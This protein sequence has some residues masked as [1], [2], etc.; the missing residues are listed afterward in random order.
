MFFI[1]ICLPPTYS[2]SV[3]LCLLYFPCLSPTLFPASFPHFPLPL[4]YAFPFL[5][6]ML[7]L[8]LSYAFPASLLLS[9]P[10][11]YTCP[12]SLLRFPCLSPM[13]SLPPS[14]AFPASLLHFPCLS[15]I[16][17][18]PLSYTCL[19]SQSFTVPCDKG[20]LLRSSIVASLGYDALC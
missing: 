10:L 7:S 4:S 13:L 3:S 6:P 19:T 12:A 14:Y 1:L 9:L 16:L 18:L 11:S 15:P 5:S 20:S 8:P 17:S 2:L